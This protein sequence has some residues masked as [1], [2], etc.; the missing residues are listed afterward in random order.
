MNFKLYA[1]RAK[2]AEQINA[3]YSAALMGFP[4]DV[5]PYRD[6]QGIAFNHGFDLAER[7]IRGEAA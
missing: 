5:N 3:G 4:R 6:E 2:Y 1:I 7:D